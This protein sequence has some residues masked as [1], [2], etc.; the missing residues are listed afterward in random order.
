MSLDLLMRRSLVLFA[1]EVWKD[2]FDGNPDYSVL[3]QS[4]KGGQKAEV[5]TVDKSLVE[6]IEI[7]LLEMYKKGRKGFVLFCHALAY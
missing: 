4:P 3:K 5:A 1:R 2:C 7:G 6:K